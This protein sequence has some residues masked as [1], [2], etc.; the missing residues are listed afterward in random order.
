MHGITSGT[1]ITSTLS[2]RV[3][4]MSAITATHTDV[5]NIRRK[6]TIADAT[7]AINGFV[8]RE[9]KTRFKQGHFIHL[10]NVLLKDG[11]VYIN[12]ITKD[13]RYFNKIF[14]FHMKLMDFEISLS[15][16]STFLLY[17]SPSHSHSLYLYPSFFLSIFPLLFFLC[18]S[19]PLS[20]S[21]SLS[22]SFNFNP[23][24]F[25]PLD[26]HISLSP[27]L[28]LSL[29]FSLSLSLTLSL[30]LSSYCL[31]SLSKLT[32][33]FYTKYHVICKCTQ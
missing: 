26:S 14:I 28:S 5:L 15:L 12:D 29:F 2:V 21:P 27:S 23:Y 31:L 9:K 24:I 16:I 22:P 18:L 6:I 30:F 7:G 8:K 33:T 10:I 1:T 4:R 17:F 32:S 25:S 11:Y 13:F 3:I 20:L 19:L